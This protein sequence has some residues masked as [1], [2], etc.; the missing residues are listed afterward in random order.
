MFR[1]RVLWSV[2]AAVLMAAVVS[3]CGGGGGSSGTTPGGGGGGNGVT[4]AAPTMALDLVNAAGGS[5]NLISA[6]SVVSA[7]ATIKNADGS[8]AAGVRVT[9][10]GDT[11]LVKFSPAASTLTDAN[12]VATVQVASASLSAAGAGTLSAAA[13][14]AG[15]TLAAQKDFQV[16]AAN[17]TLGSLSLGNAG[18]PA[19]G[20]Q[21]ISVTALINGTPASATPVQ[22][23]F[24]ASCGSITP[25][26]MTTDATGKAAT[27]YKA[28]SA[29]CSGSNVTI[30]ASAVGATPISGTVAVQPAIAT[31]VAFVNALPDRI[32]L[33]GSVGATQSQVNFKVVDAGGNPLQ[34][35]SVQLALVNSGPGVS[36]NTLGN[37]VPVTLTTDSQGLVSVAVFS[38]TVPTSL[39]VRASLAANASLNTTSNTLIV[40]SG[41]AVQKATSVSLSK[42][43]IEGANVDGETTNVTISLADRQGNPVPD[44]TEVSF[45]SETGVMIPPRC[46]VAGGASSCSVTLRSQGTRTAN[47]K[48]SVLA[49]VPGEED[50]VDSNVNNVYDPGESFED[51]GNAYRDDNDDNAFNQGEFTVPRAGTV[52]CSGGENGRPDTCDGVWG[53]VDVRKQVMVVFATSQARW[54]VR[55]RTQAVLELQVSDL[56][57]NSMPT[58]STITTLKLGGTDVCTVTTSSP[59]TVPNLYGPLNVVVNLDKCTTGDVIRATITTPRG[60]GTFIDVA[61]P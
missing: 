56:N 13:T 8:A 44:G 48:V 20:N 23:T 2:V 5:T 53:A 42:F 16:A 18:V 1:F 6:S 49:Y 54:T 19:F 17:L 30:T 40:A 34:N 55:T 47:G 26:A 7:K 25:A 31:N 9:F 36:I 59:A 39:Q 35:Q 28:D 12:G 4:P 60:L 32:Y 3:A 21:A 51:L 52:S 15:V 37:T 57:G 33:A 61:L 24:T 50:F 14:V 10:T 22:V 11:T 58:G 38:G 29:N 27:T 41:R 45:V 46:V 43:S